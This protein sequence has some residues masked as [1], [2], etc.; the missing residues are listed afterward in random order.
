MPHCVIIGA[1]IIGMLTAR[2]L[3]AAG[4]RVTL[5]DRGRAG[6]E[7]SWAG[8][9][10]IS[11]LHPWRYADPVS[12][13]ARWSQQH[14]P[15]V[16]R[17]LTESTGIDPQWNRNGLLVLGVD[18]QEQ[19]EIWARRWDMDLRLLRGDEL[20]ACEPALGK[21]ETGALWLPDIAQVRN[22]RLVKSLKADL[23]ARGVKIHE[24]R[25][26]TGIDTQAGRVAGVYT[27]GDRI[28]AR[29]VLLAAGAWSGALMESVGLNGPI[30]PVRGQMILFRATTELVKR[31]VLHGNR[32]LIPR[33]DGRILM[34]STLEYAGFD[35]STS[36]E[37]REE[38]RE[39]AL[40]L[41]PR[42]GD[43]PIE[44]H[45][46]GLRPGKEDAIPI[47]GEHPGIGGLYINSGHFRNGVVLGL[48]S[49]RLVANL[50]LGREPALD[51]TPYTPRL[52]TRNLSDSG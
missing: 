2:E 15:E 7:S 46:A 23:L 34:G 19:A 51:P 41:V 38:L 20:T 31:I 12:A 24:N 26:V 16:C 13:L 11:P 36:E 10:I 35:K 14:Y 1:G 42:L 28:P 40:K 45:W 25:E 37:A 39:S 44:H 49:A 21:P 8:G 3:S 43:Y 6:Q 22:P 18:E 5:L 30:Q 9:G 48:A 17:A 33:R 52:R 4:H 32:Y 29:Q 50:M 27:A 47:I